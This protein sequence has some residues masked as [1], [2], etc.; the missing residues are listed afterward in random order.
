METLEIIIGMVF[1]YLLV[2][3]LATIVQELWASLTSLRGKILLKAIAKLLEV[4]NRSAVTG[5]AKSKLFTEFKRR[6]ESSQIYQKYSDRY[7]GL[8]QLPSYLSAEQV[9]S[10]IKELLEKD[11][12]MPTASPTEATRDLNFVPQSSPEPTLLATMQQDDLRKQ[13]EIIYQGSPTVPLPGQRSLA[14]GADLNVA[15]D[16]VAKAKAGFKRQ[17]DEIMDR[18]TD[19][20]KRGIQ[21]NLITIGFLI[22]ISFDADTFKIYSNLTSHPESRQE[23]LQLAEN[24]IDNDQ[25]TFYLDTINQIRVVTDTA[26]AAAYRKLLDKYIIDQ[27]ETVPSPLGLGWGKEPLPA[28]PQDWIIKFLGWVVTALAISLGAPF[29]FDLLKKLISI[30]SA[31][32]RPPTATEKDKGVTE[33]P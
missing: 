18:A 30:R 23:L 20:Y 33:E 27:I 32:T 31:G 2:S 12:A 10:I 25:T 6:V 4:E 16:L 8:K 26:R 29:W 5:E 3:L 21:W 7:L 9:T 24:Y 22:A 17:Y 14:D 1:I 11:T 13:L 15:E 28:R 19:W